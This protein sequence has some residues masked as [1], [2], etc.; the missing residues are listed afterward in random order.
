MTLMIFADSIFDRDF[1]NGF[2]VG[3]I[4]A[5]F[6]P[7]LASSVWPLSASNFIKLH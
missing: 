3:I 7:S 1:E 6:S 2:Y 4:F 5:L